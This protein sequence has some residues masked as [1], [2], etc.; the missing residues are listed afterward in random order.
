MQNKNTIEALNVELST[1]RTL[2]AGAMEQA[3]K[4][5]S[6]IYGMTEQN[7]TPDKEKMI[8]FVNDFVDENSSEIQ[9]DLE[10]NVF[11]IEID[12]REYTNQV[13]IT[14]EKDICSMSLENVL[15]TTLQKFVDDYFYHK[16]ESGKG[17]ES[18]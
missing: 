5:D 17:S 7:E 6:I 10:E 18:E 11:E 1:L 12:T 8:D 15:K 16:N 3:N 14:A 4:I 9:Y 13:T 2:L